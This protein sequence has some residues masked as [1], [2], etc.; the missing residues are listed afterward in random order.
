MLCVAVLLC[1]GVGGE[2]NGMN[3]L[4]EFVLLL[5]LVCVVNKEK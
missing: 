4:F 5:C 2:K 3:G 1:G